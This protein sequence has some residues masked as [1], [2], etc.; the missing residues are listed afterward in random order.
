MNRRTIHKIIV[1]SWLAL[2]IFLGYGVWSFQ[3]GELMILAF[4]LIS[5]IAYMLYAFLARC[6]ACNMPLMLR[7]LTLFGMELYVWSLLTPERCRHC[8]T[9]NQ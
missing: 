2:F 4:F 3:G 7:P 9:I 6:P 1:V 5:S 8:E